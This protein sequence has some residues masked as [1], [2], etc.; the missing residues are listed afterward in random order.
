MTLRTLISGYTA[1]SWQ[2]RLHMIVRWRVCPLRR[3][4][5]HVPASGTILDLGCGHG[6]FAQLL[7]RQS[8]DRSVLGIDLDAHKIALAQQL[9]LPNLRFV[10]GGGAQAVLPPAGAITILDVFFF[11]PPSPQEH[12]LSVFAHKLGSRAAT[13]PYE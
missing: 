9:A 5:A 2:D 13:L 12:L 3:I 1:L 10:A 7:A 8:K 6:L 11:F 4:A